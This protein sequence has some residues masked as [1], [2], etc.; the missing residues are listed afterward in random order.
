MAGTG[1]QLGPDTL[2][3]ILLAERLDEF[4]ARARRMDPADLA[5]FIEDLESDEERERVFQL[6]D[7]ETASE[8]IVELESALAE[9]LLEDMPSHEIASLAAQMAPDEAAD[10]IGEMDEPRGAEVL[11]AMG[12]DARADVADLLR[13]GEDTAGGLMTTEVFSCTE[14]ETVGDVRRRL[15]SSR[16]SDP[17]LHAYVVS[18]ENGRLL[19]Y[20]PL[21]E[22]IA[23]DANA[24]IRTLIH[25]ECVFCAVGDDQQSVAMLFRKYDLWVIP[26]VDE[27]HRLAGRIT[28]DDVIDVVYEE[29][30]ADLAHMVGAPD[31]E[32]EEA[33]LFR[34]TRLRLPWLLIT[35]FAGLLNSMVIRA[36]M[37]IT[38]QEMLAIFVPPILAMGGN[39]GM[40]S[41]AVC[42]RGIALGE[43]KY[44]RIWSVVRREIRVGLCLGLV[45]GLLTGATVWAA[46]SWLVSRPSLPPLRLGLTVG[47]AMTNAMVFASSFGALV[48]IVLHRAGI[49][50]AVASG[51]FISTS[52][53]LSATLIYFATCAL[54]V[55]LG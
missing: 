16:F 2:R 7:A 9:D 3:E 35:M 23:A 36:M 55:G 51:P 28:V 49:D 24:P 12:P 5:D 11:A 43:R 20:V 30:D 37:H 1:E 32:E 50:P 33:A 48:P 22:L 34:V 8:M 52:N 17:V 54:I 31:I 29:A 4:R 53:D 6:L 39:T 25:D 27:N 42:V 41:A 19:G 15:L 10:F 26:V 21:Q 13:H 45:C 38:T 14:G 44:N 46:M 18:V 47:L 40:Q